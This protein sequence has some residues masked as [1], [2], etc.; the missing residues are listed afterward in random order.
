MVSALVFAVIVSHAQGKLLTMP[1]SSTQQKASSIAQDPRWQL[2]LQRSTTADGRFVYAVRTTGIYC[3]ASC[4]SRQP[5]P[6]N[7]IFFADGLAAQAAG[8]RP[9]LRCTPD[10]ASPQQRQADLIVKACQ[11]ISMLDGT[12][13]LQALA[14]EAG[15]SPYHFHRL[16]KK[17]TGL[18]PRAYAMAIRHQKLQQKLATATSIT[19]AIYDAGYQSSS[20]FYAESTQRLGMTPRNFRAGG[21]Q[22]SIYFAI[23]QCSLGAILVAQSQLGICAILLGDDP[24]I[25]L[26]QLQDQFPQAEL[27]GD[28][29][30]F[31]QQM[32][33]VIALIDNPRLGLELPLDIRGTAF[34]QRVWQ[35]LR[36][37]PPGQTMSYAELAAKI[38]QPSAVR[39]VARACA[40]N[41]LAVAIPCHRVIRQNGELSGYR[42]GLARKQAL[43][44]REENN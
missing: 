14:S 10:Q 24:A 19:D 4:P 44:K 15:M 12:P 36:D 5:K 28:E 40:A 23:G 29:Q 18:T 25:L 35:A 42:W 8:F 34:Q 22:T 38:G 33:T 11:H 31:E 16:F 17:T 30:A 43:L 32:A 39:A 37:I 9:C 7:V 27:H 13:S 26:Q 41:T 20:R 6:E 1:S 3:R 21:S 2:V